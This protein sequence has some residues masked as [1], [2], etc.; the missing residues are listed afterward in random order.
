MRRI[1]DVSGLVTRD[2]GFYWTLLGKK[3]VFSRE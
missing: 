1:D 3:K 2:G